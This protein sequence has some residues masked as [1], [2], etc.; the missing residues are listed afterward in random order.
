MSKIV[1]LSIVLLILLGAN[2]ATSKILFYDDCENKWIVATEWNESNTTKGSNYA[3]VSS[4]QA[5]AGSHSYKL[6]VQPFDTNNV[7]AT[8]SGL[9]LRGVNSPVLIKNFL[10]DQEYWLGFSIYVPS[11]YS[12]P[13]KYNK[14]PDGQGEWQLFWQFHGI[15]DPCDTPGL[16]PNIGGFLDTGDS[17]PG[18]VVSIKGD[19]RECITK[20]Y[21]RNTSQTTPALTKGAWHDI[22]MNVKFSYSSS[23]FYRL[24]LNGKQVVNDSGMNCYKQTKG[25]Y[26]IMGPYGH[27]E[28]ATTLYY[29]EIRVGDQN[30]SYAEVAPKGSAMPSSGAVSL[31]PPKLQ[32]ISGK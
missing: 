2:P 19:N 14:L 23:G 32:V 25:P 26:F 20:S 21:V 18:Y 22:I 6:Y 27:M 16:N 31:D 24:W 15:Q 29:D 8:N 11:S 28:K 7:S 3:T 30:S 1:S 17:T 12:W 10:F 13:S 9:L 5:R 4:E